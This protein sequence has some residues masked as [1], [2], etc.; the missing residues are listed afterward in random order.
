MLCNDFSH[1]RKQ[2]FSHLGCSRK[3][4][5]ETYVYCGDACRFGVVNNFFCVLQLGVK[6]VEDVL[7]KHFLGS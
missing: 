7:V 3:V 1:D 2:S 6:S 4:P 5:A